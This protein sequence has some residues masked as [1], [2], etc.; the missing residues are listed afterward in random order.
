VHTRLSN[1]DYNSSDFDEAL[2][3][4]KA[5][6]ERNPVDPSAHMNAGNSLERF[7]QFDAAK[8]ELLAAIRIK[9][10]FRVAHQNLGILL[11][12][13]GHQDEAIEQFKRLWPSSAQ[14]FIT[15]S[16]LPTNMKTTI[17]RAIEIAEKLQPPDGRL[18]EA[19][20]QLG[21]VYAWRLDYKNAEALYKR[22]LPL[23]EKL[24]GGQSPMIGPAVQD[25]AMLGMARKDFA[26][27]EA[28][29][30]RDLDL[31]RETY[32]EN[33]NAVAESLLG[34]AHVY[35]AHH[36]YAKAEAADLRVVS[37]S[38]TMYGGDDDYR[39]AIPLT[40]LCFV[41]DQWGKPDNAQPCHARLVSL[42]EKP[43]GSD[44]PLVSDL[45]AEAQ[46]LRQLGRAEEATK[47]ETRTKA[48]QSAQTS[49]HWR[50]FLASAWLPNLP[51]LSSWRSFAVACS[52]H[53]PE[54]AHDS[55]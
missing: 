47:I 42:E 51:A 7:R 15:I 27:S 31:N 52:L 24:Y 41:N 17:Q 3:H 13:S 6:E 14:K 12:D 55:H 44:S 2:Q 37:I 9:P 39:M 33:S 54:S 25:L 18:P 16:A 45:T 53:Q 5:A 30:S 21:T 10:D 34:I 38:E 1:T 4:A 28:L 46:A 40:T 48:I 36:N 43:F 8:S 32:G 20:G 35:P 26:G 49:P 29:F 50:G 19:V 22:Q 11:G 23:S